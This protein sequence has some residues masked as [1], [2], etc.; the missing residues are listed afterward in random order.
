MKT[1]FVYWDDLSYQLI[2]PDNS[3]SIINVQGKPYKINWDNNQEHII[4]NPNNYSYS[5][6]NNNNFEY[7]VIGD[8]LAS[9]STCKVITDGIIR[10]NRYHQNIDL[11]NQ[12][13]SLIY[14]YDY[15]CSN[16]NYAWQKNGSMITAWANQIPQLYN[17]KF[18]IWKST[19]L[20]NIVFKNQNYLK[21][22]KIIDNNVAYHY[23]ITNTNSIQIIN[24]NPSNKIEIEGHQFDIIN[25]DSARKDCT[26]QCPLDTITCDCGNERCCYKQVEHGYQLVKTINL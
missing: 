16:N 13:I 10:F 8:Y 6:D 12:S 18:A 20:P 21:L 5:I 9:Y 14:N 3:F 7:Y 1:C 11:T 4:N 22:L 19:K 25:T 23:P 15:Q 17:N 26:E 2:N 24:S